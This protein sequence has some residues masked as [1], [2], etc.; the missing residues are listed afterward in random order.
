MLVCDLGG[1]VP[2]AA[3]SAAA[4]ANDLL[5]LR[6]L[7]GTGGWSIGDGVDAAA[8]CTG[9]ACNGGDGG[10]LFGCGGGDGGRGGLLIGNGG[11]GAD[12]LASTNPAIAGGDGGRGGDAGPLGSG[13]RGG[14]GGAGA[15]WTNG[16]KGTNAGDWGTGGKW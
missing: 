2:G 9:D 8:D 6:P 15:G 16:A 1:R 4:T 7:I 13:G 14:A 12:G 5:P 11:D 3:V 10:W